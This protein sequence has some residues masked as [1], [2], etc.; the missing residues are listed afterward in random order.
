MH[1][2]KKK[3]HVT[4]SSKDTS[5]HSIEEKKNLLL[6]P[7]ISNVKIQALIVRTSLSFTLNLPILT[8]LL[9]LLKMKLLLWLAQKQEM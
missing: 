3:N 1:W 2:V 9:I 6:I 5:S 7:G 4:L 8:I